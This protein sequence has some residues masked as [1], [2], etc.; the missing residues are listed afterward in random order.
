MLFALRI[1]LTTN[2][3]ANSRVIANRRVLGVERVITRQI[4]GFLPAKA[5]ILPEPGAPPQRVPFFQGEPQ[6]MRFVSTFSL[7]EAGRGYPRILEYQVI[8]GEKGGVRLILNEIL[9]TG[10][11]SAGLLGAG[12]AQV[13]GSQFPVPRYRPV[14]IGPGSFVLADRLSQCQFFYKLELDDPNQDRWL[15][16][17]VRA[18]R[19]AA[20]RIDMAPLEPDPS[21][22]HVPS[23]TARFRVD[24]DPTVEYRQWE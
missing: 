19:P 21:K 8:P 22:L 3:R 20:V 18:E 4:A 7:Q 24:R 5:D 9:Y 2:E 1:G 6:T 13:P 11:Q 10:P 16:R 14:Q 17:W 15:P 23:I 12:F